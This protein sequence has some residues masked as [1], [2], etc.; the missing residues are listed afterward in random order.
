MAMENENGMG[1]LS[2]WGI[3]IFFLILFWIF[4]GGYGFNR[5][6]WGNNF[7]CNDNVC[8]GIRCN[9]T[10]NCEMEQRS[11]VTAADTNYRIIAE[12]QASTNTIMNALRSQ[13]DAEQGEKIFDLKMNSLAQ[14]SAANL[15]LAQKDATIERLTLQR[16]LDAQFGTIRAELRDL[17]CNVLKKP[18]VTGI[19]VA[20]PSA[21]IANGM[22][23]NN[24]PLQQAANN[25]G[26]CNTCC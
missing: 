10:T 23:L 21:G 24:F 7:G 19:G 12:N 22:G 17:D 5:G 14:Q 1:G 18:N 11:L 26:C 25:C 15:A 3:V 6:G 20:C 16:H 2:V 13:W 9:A 8:S 4:T